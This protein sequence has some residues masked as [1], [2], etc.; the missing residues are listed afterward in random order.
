VTDQE[1]VGGELRREEIEVGAGPDDVANDVH[2]RPFHQHA[3]TAPARVRTRSALPP[4]SPVHRTP[5]GQV[6][7]DRRNR[8]DLH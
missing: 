2:R 1:T 8:S 7:D 6:P 3:D 4:S 5:A